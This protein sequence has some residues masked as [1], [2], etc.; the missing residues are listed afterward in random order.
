MS[1]SKKKCQHFKCNLK[2]L[3]SS[4]L[5][6]FCYIIVTGFIYF[7]PGSNTL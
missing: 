4:V 5:I 1:K 6:T 7:I 2:V 3:N